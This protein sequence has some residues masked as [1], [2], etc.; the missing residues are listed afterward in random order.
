MN[1]PSQFR[2]QLVALTNMALV[3]RALSDR[4]KFLVR[5]PRAARRLLFHKREV[6]RCFPLAPIKTSWAEVGWGSYSLLVLTEPFEMEILPLIDEEL[7]WHID[8][9][10]AFRD[11]SLEEHF[12]R[13]GCPFKLEERVAATPALLAANPGD[14]I[15]LVA[16]REGVVKVLDGRHRLAI[17]ISQGLRKIR[18]MVAHPAAV[19]MRPVVNRPFW[20]WFF[21]PFSPERGV[22]K[23]WISRFVRTLKMCFKY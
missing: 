16:I 21:L 13:P 23:S 6:S 9:I 1:P 22:K 17:A 2:Y 14:F 3:W 11:G 19:P 8:E 10:D 18:V 20:S 5:V 7:R 12:S 15:I 4:A